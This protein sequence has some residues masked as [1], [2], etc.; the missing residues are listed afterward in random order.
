MLTC[1]EGLYWDLMDSWGDILVPPVSVCER[2]IKTSRG[3]CRDILTAT[4]KRPSQHPHHLARGL[5]ARLLDLLEQPGDP[6]LLL[7][8][9][10]RHQEHLLGRG[11]VVGDLAGRHGLA[12][13]DRVVSVQLDPATWGGG[14]VDG[15]DGGGVGGGDGGGRGGGG[16]GDGGDSDSLLV[17]VVMVVMVMMVMMV[18]I[19]PTLI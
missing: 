6:E 16:G 11:W 12:H 17:R 5:E 18:V 2:G 15:G 9:A 3:Q 8:H 7:L 10:G 14:G 4:S 19:S 13:P 1:T